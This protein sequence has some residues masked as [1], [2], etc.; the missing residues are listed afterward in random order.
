MMSTYNIQAG[1]MI[2]GDSLGEVLATQA[3]GTEFRSTAPTQ[4]PGMSACACNCSPG[5][6]DGDG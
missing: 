2:W 3:W 1:K 6:D 4:E 5:E